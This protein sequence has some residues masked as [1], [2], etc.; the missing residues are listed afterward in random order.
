MAQD[1]FP[2]LRELGRQEFSADIL[3]F[4]PPYR[5]APY[6]DLLDI[7]FRTNVA[8]REAVCIIEHHSKAEVPEEGPAYVL[9]RVVKQGDKRLSFYRKKEDSE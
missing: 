5:F 4:D 3:F 7:V 2:T 8:A 6:G 9:S 1:A